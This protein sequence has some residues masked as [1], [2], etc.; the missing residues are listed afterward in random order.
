MKACICG[1]HILLHLLRSYP[2]VSSVSLSF[3]K[4]RTTRNPKK[5][6]PT[7]QLPPPPLPPSSRGGNPFLH[8]QAVVTSPF[9]EI[10]LNHDGKSRTCLGRV[11]VY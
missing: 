1:G 8:R 5:K 6:N 3:K 9:L 10:E 7:D 4:P 11:R 2:F